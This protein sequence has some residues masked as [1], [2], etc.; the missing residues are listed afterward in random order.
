MIYCIYYYYYYLLIDISPHPLSTIKEIWGG[1]VSVVY[2]YI[3]SA[4][5]S[6]WEFLLQLSGNKPN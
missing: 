4:K 6:T 3:P 2:Q 1:G 5:N